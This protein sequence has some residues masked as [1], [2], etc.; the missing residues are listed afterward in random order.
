MKPTIYVP[1]LPETTSKKIRIHITQIDNNLRVTRNYRLSVLSEINV[2]SRELYL[3]R[4]RDSVIPSIEWVVVFITHSTGVG[5]EGGV[6]G[7]GAC[8]PSHFFDW[9]GGA[10][11][12]LCPCPPPPPHTLL[13]PHFHFPLELYVYLTLTNNYL[14]FFIYQLIILWII[15]IN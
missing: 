3:S 7:G 5:S 4:D 11:V 2:V 1:K 8:A 13:T 10:M 15:S 9:G 6:K 12:C 14:A